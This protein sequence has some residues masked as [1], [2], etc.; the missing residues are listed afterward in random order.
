[1]REREERGVKRI[2]V[3]PMVP[4]GRHVNTIVLLL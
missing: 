2:I 1:M 3:G 4:H